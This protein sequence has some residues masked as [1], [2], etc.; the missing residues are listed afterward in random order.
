MKKIY[1]YKYILINEIQIKLFSGLKMDRKYNKFKKYNWAYSD[2]WQNY[3]RNLYPSP[4]ISKLLHYKKKFY[5]NYID[6]DFDINYI[7]PEGEVQETSYEPPPDIIRKNLKKLKKQ[8]AKENNNNESNND[9]EEETPYEKLVEKY[10]LAKENCKPIKSSLYKYAEIF[11]I[12]SFLLSIPLGI[13]TI[14]MSLYAFLI[15]VLREVGLPSFSKKYFQ[16]LFMNDSFHTLIY[17]IICYLDYFNYYML[18]PVA[19][20]SIVA[21]SEELKDNKLMFNYFN[22]Y[23]SSVNKVKEKLL[24]DKTHIE[25]VIGFLQIIGASIGINT[26]KTPI[27]FWHILRFRYIVNPYV[28]K[29]F[30]EFNKIIEDFK[31]SNKCPRF[32]KYIIEKLQVVF[33]YLGSISFNKNNKKDKENDKN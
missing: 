22:N 15:K 10:E 2:D 28:N 21:I 19:I 11:F 9:S 23:I 30:A 17:I 13:K 16:C 5:R 8:K 7:P 26:F 29:S 33:N 27:I 20:S 4:P 6:P 12:I 25:I 3:Y 24:Q 32:L 14:Q 1:A 18:L 31:E